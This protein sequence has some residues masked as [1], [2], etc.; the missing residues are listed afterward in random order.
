M[1]VSSARKPVRVLLADDHAMFREGLA[2]LLASYSGIE[3]VAKAPNDSE[4]AELARKHRPDVVIMEA[5][6]PLKRAKESLLEIRKLSPSPKVVICTMFEEPRYVRELMELGVSA[7]L[8][9]NASVKHLIGAVRS[10]VFGPKGADVG[11]GRPREMLEEAEGSEG[12]LS[13]REM[14][15]LILAARG[16]SNRQIATSLNL[17]EAT[18]KRHLSN[19]YSKMGISSRGEA[20]R[21]ALGEGWIIIQDILEKGT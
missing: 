4:V 8:T 13:P 18:I 20:V 5:Q 15:V 2:K 17:S 10:A 21:K 16:L 7:C 11:V 9:K 14:E 19:C 12:V 1:D 6:I 3:V